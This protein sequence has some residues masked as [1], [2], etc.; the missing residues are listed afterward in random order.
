[1]VYD[2]LSAVFHI[3]AVFKYGSDIGALME[4]KEWVEQSLQMKDRKK[5]VEN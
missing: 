3:K 1:L 4:T 2:L 5:L